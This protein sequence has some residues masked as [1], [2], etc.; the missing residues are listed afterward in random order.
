MLAVQQP[1]AH[2]MTLEGL[3]PQFE[4]Q[5]AIQE[6]A[7]SAL[8]GVMPADIYRT[9]N[10]AAFPQAMAF[11]AGVPSS[12]LSSRPDLRQAAFALN[13]ANGDVG[14]AKAEF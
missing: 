8:C 12:L 11:P 7:I 5:V 14:C 3:V 6:A 13:K 9:G 4:Q 2:K 10:L 1:N